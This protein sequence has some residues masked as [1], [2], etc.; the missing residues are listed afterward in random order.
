MILLARSPF[1]LIIIFLSGGIIFAR[2]YSFVFPVMFCLFFLFRKKDLGVILPLIFL[3]GFFI[4]GKSVLE[5]EHS[6][7]HQL[8]GEEL[9]IR[10][11]IKDREGDRLLLEQV[12]VKTSS[13]W[14]EIGGGYWAWVNGSEKVEV[15][16]I[17]EGSGYLNPLKIPTNP[18][19]PDWRMQNLAGKVWGNIWLKPDSVKVVGQQRAPLIQVRLYLEE[20]M[21][22]ALGKEEKRFLA[23][24]LLGRRQDLVET[25]RETFYAAGL[26]HVLA[27]SGLHIGF[28]AFLLWFGL[29]KLPLG[30][31]YKTALFCLLIL[32]YIGLVGWRASV[33]R[34]GIMTIGLRLGEETKREGN[35]FNNLALAYLILI[36]SN[37]FLLWTAGFQLSF[38]LT[39]FI[40][41][42]K[43]IIMPVKGR[44]RQGFLFSIL[45]TLAA[46]PLT[47][48]HFQI[49]NP[50]NFLGN[51]WALPLTG[52]VVMSG[53]CG[54]VPLLGDILWRLITLPAI[55]VMKN[56]LEI[57]ADLPGTSLVV[58]SPPLWAVTIY[59]FLLFSIL[60]WLEPT[61]VPLWQKYKTLMV[62]RPLP[63][64]IIIIFLVLI[65]NGLEEKQAEI[66]FLDVGQGDAIHIFLPEAG[67]IMIDA[68]GSWGQEGG[69]IGER[70]ILPYLRERGIRQLDTI[71]ISHFHEDHYRG[72]LPV[73]EQKNTGVVFG[74]PLQEVWQEEEFFNKLRKKASDYF[75]L[76]R[77]KEFSLGPSNSLRVLHPGEDLLSQSP[78]NNNSLVLN[79]E[80]GRWSFLLTGDIEGEAEKELVEKGL[81]PDVDILKVA[82]HGSSTSTSLPFIEEARP[83]FAIIQVGKNQFGHPDPGVLKRLEDMGVQ[84]FITKKHGAVTFSVDKEGNLRVKKWKA[85]TRELFPYTNLFISFQ[86][87]PRSGKVNSPDKKEEKVILSKN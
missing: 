27:V 13:V 61:R 51:L 40:I 76:K 38:L 6:E 82:H 17:L 79:L 55:M 4:W 7:I 11:W 85:S 12:E 48:Y 77:G 81:V 46:S 16:K 31:K 20:R 78:L 45:A 26:G 72:F 1:V 86:K 57:W 71:F 64:L 36:L 52:I 43:N 56:L 54:M 34:A 84:V 33:A 47:A 69:A 39:F 21:E 66:T 60:F 32:I 42:G 15:G 67:D 65:F 80:I 24:L 2:G 75:P 83:L 8:T 87:F 49:I 9:L 3:L 18:G 50:L 62:K 37:P 19:E 35:L 14:R 53:F 63:I 28:I 29:E 59:Y 58:P 73:L 10:G 23:A 25:Q 30:S 70:I 22:R 41:L 44:I 74:P 68:G 5:Y